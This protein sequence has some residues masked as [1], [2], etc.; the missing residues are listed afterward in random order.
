MSDQTHPVGKK[1]Q[2]AFGLY[3]M[4]GNVWEWVEDWFRGY[5][6]EAVTDPKGPGAGSIRVYRGGSFLNIAEYARSAYRY[7]R[8]PGYRHGYL[9][10]RL[11]RTAL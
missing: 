11:L 5:S 8:V 1:D 4:H 2:N 6:S 7:Y 9:G 3:D 10:F